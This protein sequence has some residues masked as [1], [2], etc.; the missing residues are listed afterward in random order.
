MTNGGKHAV[1]SAFT[2]L[3]DDG[4]EVLLPAPFWTTYP[5]PIALAGGV[6]VVLPTD[7]S[8][9]FRVT[10]DQLEAA[11]TPR[12]K[13]LVFVSPSN[14]TGRGLPAR[15]D[16]GHRPLGARARHRGHHRRDLR[17][18][19]LRRRRA[20]LHRGGRPRARRAVRHRQRRRQDLRHD[21]VAGRLA[22]RPGRRGQ[23]RH[24]PADASH[25]ER[26]QRRP[27]RSA[28]GGVGRPLRGRA[29]AAG[30]RPPAAHDAP[31]A[32]R[33]PRCQLPRARGR[34]LRLPEPD[35]PAGRRPRAAGARRPPSSWPTWSWRT[36][37]SRSCRARRSDRPAT[38][39]SRSPSAT[40]TWW[41]ASSGWPAW[42]AAG[43]SA[44]SHG[45]RGSHRRTPRLVA[46]A[47]VRRIGPRSG[48]PGSPGWA[49]PATH[50]G[51]ATIWWS[52]SRPAQQGSIVL[53]G[54]RADGT[55]VDL[56]PQRVRLRS[57][58]NE[59]GGGAF[60]TGQGH[61]DWVDD[62]SQQLMRADVRRRDR[63]GGRARTVRSAPRRPG[64]WHGATHRVD[65]VG[66][67][68]VGGR[69]A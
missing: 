1:Y 52:E 30:L 11:R 57:R 27:A 17:A 59:Y 58:V 49:S 51:V 56:D 34:V 61:V 32:G 2:V 39:G 44:A 48:R 6:S 67:G 10:V 25:V 35:G 41:R 3:I 46:L 62:S 37:R 9:G 22:H 66:A 4:D 24:Q 64:S 40:T 13:A 60:W 63:S 7:E 28:R 36:R 26:L 21:R 14:P 31:D 43:D 8:T 55:P 65:A 45:R 5:E 33:H 18:P 47:V 38:A 69:R 53:V 54:A 23:G 50:D 12:T 15:R 42:S 20:P 68:D 29:D 19:R 16:R